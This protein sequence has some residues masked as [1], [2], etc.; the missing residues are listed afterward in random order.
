MVKSANPSSTTYLLHL[1]ND[2]SLAHDGTAVSRFFLGQPNYSQQV[3]LEGIEHAATWF[4]P[5]CAKKIH[6]YLGM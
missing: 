1:T 6:V 5:S 4:L 3:I 2:T